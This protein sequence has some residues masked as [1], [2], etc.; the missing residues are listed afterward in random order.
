M[1]KH[2]QKRRRRT[3]ELTE[4]GGRD[5]EE[6]QRRKADDTISEGE[7]RRGA[8]DGGGD[9]DGERERDITVMF[10]FYY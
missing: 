8:A 10:S 4:M 7:T 6:G 9:G 5:G 3:L 2:K 1:P